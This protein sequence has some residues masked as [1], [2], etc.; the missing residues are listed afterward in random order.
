MDARY[1]PDCRGAEDKRVVS[2]IKYFFH[3]EKYIVFNV[4]FKK[5]IL[6]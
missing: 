3:A 1:K 6:I 5:G 2:M 4:I